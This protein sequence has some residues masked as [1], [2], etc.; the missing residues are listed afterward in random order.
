MKSNGKFS[1]RAFFW[2]QQEFSASTF[3]PG[4]RTKGVCQHIRSELDEL[5]KAVASGDRKAILAEIVDIIILAV[6]LAWRH[7]FKSAEVERGL[8]AKLSKNMKRK[9]PD[10][11]VVGQDKPIEHVRG[12]H[13]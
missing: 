3:G 7:G 12:I 1:F 8:L 2:S 5:E 10:W 13:D 4:N 6:D 9:W 11:R